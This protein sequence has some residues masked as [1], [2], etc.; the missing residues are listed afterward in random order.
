MAS[1]Q[2]RPKVARF[3]ARWKAHQHRLD[4]KRLVFL[5]ET[6]IKTNM[7]RMCGWAAKGKRLTAQVPHGHWKTLTF[8]AGLRHDRIVAPFMLDGP[9]NADAFTA[10]VEQCLVPTLEPGDIVVADNLRSHKGM[11]ARKLIRD[12]GAHLLFLPPY[13]PDLNPIEMVFAK[14]KTLFRKADERSVEASWR[15]VGTLLDAFTPGECQNYL[16]HA[17]YASVRS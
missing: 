17:G 5:D 11:P 3:R 4:P 7:T 6:W 13:S 8:L 15:R 16:R 14:L 12:A 10:W 2:M 9:I 1:E